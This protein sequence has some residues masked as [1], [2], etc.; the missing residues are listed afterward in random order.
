MGMPEA[1]VHLAVREYLR[2]DGW[3]LI[4]GQWPGGS[5]DELHTLNIMDP[6]VAR[7]RSPDPRRHSLDKLVPDV[8]A[9]RGETLLLVEAKP[10]YSEA[11]LE[12]LERLLGPRRD[13]L[14]TA[15][16]TFGRER[17]FE[18]L[19]QPELLVIRPALAFE[20]TAIHPAPVAPW[21]LLLVDVD[22]SVRTEGRPI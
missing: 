20:A 15:L 17:G 14:H 13:D 22:R 6:T 5:D 4:A 10:D 2:A 1:V 8:V 12:K 16:R 21:L 19:L 9:I 18:S 7:D 3:T 11:D